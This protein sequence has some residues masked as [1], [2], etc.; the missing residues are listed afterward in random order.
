MHGNTHY[1][2]SG[3]FPQNIFDIL[4]YNQIF[5]RVC[6]NITQK[7]SANSNVMVCIGSIRI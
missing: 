6:E 2:C 5:E 4:L 1:S 3:I 7:N